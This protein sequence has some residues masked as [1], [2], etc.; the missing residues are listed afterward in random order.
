MRLPLKRFSIVDKIFSLIESRPT[1]DKLIMRVLFFLAIFSGIFF[2]YTVNKDHSAATPARGGVLSEGI[3]GIPRFV[4]PA[5]AITRAD[6]DTVA[7]L[8]SGLLKI[9]TEGNLISDIAESISVSEDGKTYHVTLRK[10]RTF[11]DGKPITARDA[12]YTITLV[13]DSNLKSP[14]RGNWSDVVIEEINEYEFNIVLLEAY[15]PFMENFTLGIMP[16]HIW[17]TLPI[18]QLPFSQHN[19]EPIGS[20]PFSIKIVNRDTSGLI[21]GYVLE[22]AKNRPETPNL[23]AIEL[24]FFQN[25]TTLIDAFLAGKINAT[26]YLPAARIKELVDLDI[27]VLTEPLPRIFGIFFN[28]NRS[29]ALRDES[30]RQALNIAVDRSKLITEVLYGYG[31]PTTKPILENITEVESSSTVADASTHYSVETAKEILLEGGW[32]QNEAGFW[33]KEIDESTETLSLTIKTSNN[34][35]FDKTATIVAENWRALGVEVQVEQYEQTGLVQS[36]I[37][38]RDF[39]ALLFGLD[40]NRT[41]DLYPF[42]HSSQKDDPGLNVAQYTNIAV[43]RLLEKTR[44]SQD[45]AER[46]QLLSEVSTAIN[47]ETPAVFLFAPSMAYVIDAHIVTSPLTLLSKPADRFMNVASWYAKTEVLWPIFKNRNIV[48]DIN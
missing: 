6:Q 3:V 21:S 4:N 5:L 34:E 18:E 47:T 24:Y 7:L 9:D 13:Q 17:S 32:E 48:N 2:L 12:I 19:T 46:L 14:L 29:P 45:K 26:A 35:L 27:Q 42:W 25:E 23:A 36:V 22:P 38:T 16:H 33:E 31:V 44:N 8:Y 37:R 30:A 28:Q 15:S 40:M 20:G 39:Q 1:S 41:Q 43:D 10:N 11:H